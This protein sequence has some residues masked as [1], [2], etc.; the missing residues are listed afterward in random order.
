MALLTLVGDRVP[1]SFAS[2]LLFQCPV[3]RRLWPVNSPW[4]PADARKIVEWYLALF[5]T[6]ILSLIVMPGGGIG[7]APQWDPLTLGWEWS[8]L[9]TSF[10]SHCLVNSLCWQVRVDAQIDVGLYLPLLQQE[11]LAPLAYI[12]WEMKDQLLHIFIHSTP[13]KE[14]KSVLLSRRGEWINSSLLSP[15]NTI[16]WGNQSITCFCQTRD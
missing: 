12:R 15:A 3:S 11:Y 9:D 14:S 8:R 1:L 16:Q 13:E 7:T 5:H 10:A 4:G 6:T 2:H